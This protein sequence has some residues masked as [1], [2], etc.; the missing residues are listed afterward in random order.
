[1]SGLAWWDP[2]GP[3]SAGGAAPPQPTV[4]VDHVRNWLFSQGTPTR[5]AL[6]M[7]RAIL[8]AMSKPVI[9]ADELIMALEGHSFEM[10]FFLDRRSGEVFPVFESNDESD[11]DRARIDAE[12][13]RFVAVDPIPS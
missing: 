6:L 5:V 3:E 12:P 9:D 13:A 7:D 1:M 2:V 8:G 4:T 10:T 11:A